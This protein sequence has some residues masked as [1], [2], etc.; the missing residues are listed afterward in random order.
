MLEKKGE[1]AKG[2]LERAAGIAPSRFNLRNNY[3]NSTKHGLSSEKIRMLEYSKGA[4]IVDETFRPS[5]SQIEEATKS[6]YK[7]TIPQGFTYRATLRQDSQIICT[8]HHVRIPVHF[9]DGILNYETEDDYANSGLDPENKN[10]DIQEEDEFEDRFFHGSIKHFMVASIDRKYNFILWDC[11]TREKKIHQKLPCKLN[12]IIF[13]SKN[14]MYAGVVNGCILRC[15][16]LFNCSFFTPKLD[17][18]SRKTLP[19]HVQILK[20]KE[21]THEIFAAG[22]H[23]ITVW[24]LSAVHFNGSVQIHAKLKLSMNTELNDL[25][26]SSIYIQDRSQ[27]IYV[28]IDTGFMVSSI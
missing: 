2:R 5:S 10:V 6:M 22:T 20:Y 26:L 12:H 23:D 19:H 14:Y 24:T 1:F 3:Q 9:M 21:S 4:D 27:Q 28:T 18:T 16:V 25:W 15:S 7:V 17:F 11:S 8:T 13:I